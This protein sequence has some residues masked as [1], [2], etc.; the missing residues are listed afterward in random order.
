MRNG[1]DPRV[2]QMDTEMLRETFDLTARSTSAAEARHRSLGWLTGHAVARQ[3]AETAVLIVSEF[4]AN[5]VVH[6][7]STVIRCALRFDGSLLRI[8]VTDQGNGHTS[9]AVKHAAADE[10]SGRGLL[11]VSAVSEDWG[12]FPAAPCGWTVWATV[13]MT[14]LAHRRHQQSTNPGSWLRSCDRAEVNSASAPT[15]A[16]RNTAARWQFW[17][18]S[19]TP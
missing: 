3:S 6:S 15:A 19:R 5:A 13:R 10:I 14:A 9:P 16:G 11:L 17:N 4:V 2:P 8:E 1:G 7:G 18:A 12:A